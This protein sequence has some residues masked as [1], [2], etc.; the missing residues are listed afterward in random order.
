MNLSVV[1][2]TKDSADKIK[3]C[4]ESARSITSDILV[5]DG[6]SIDGTVKIAERYGARV[7]KQLGRGYSDWRNQGIKEARG[8]W[9]FYL[10]SDERV[11]PEL[12]REIESLITGHKLAFFAYAIPRRNIILGKEM[13]HGGWWPDYVKR[14]YKKS[15]LKKWVGDLHEEP[16]FEGKMGHLKNPMV[17]LK[18]SSLSEMIEK[19]NQ[20]SEIEAKLLFDA[21]HPKM[22]WW[23]FF[24]IMLTE[25][26]YRM[27][28]KKGFLDGVEGVIYA[29]YQMW[30]KFVTYAKLWEMQLQYQKSKIKEQK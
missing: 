28:I 10:D 15:A 11:T 6:G 5:I 16:V 23:R 30:S 25:F 13:K 3:D 24:R 18:H 20:W 2:I 21:S 22:S 7:I 19:T 27:V 12:A 4:L 29:I 1:I 9:I 8:E 14:L 26:W 17:H